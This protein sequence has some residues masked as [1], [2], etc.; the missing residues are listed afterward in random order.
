MKN[1]VIT[2]FSEDFYASVEKFK[3]EGDEKEE[4]IKEMSSLT[5]KERSRIIQ[6]MLDKNQLD[7]S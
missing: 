4:F 7:K 3:W 1:G 5:P 6:E 2:A